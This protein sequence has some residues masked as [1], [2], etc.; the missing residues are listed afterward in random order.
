MG[1]GRSKSKKN[2]IEDEKPAREEIKPVAR[3]EQER[4]QSETAKSNQEV[5][6]IPKKVDV[7]TRREQMVVRFNETNGGRELFLAQI[8]GKIISLL[9]VDLDCWGTIISYLRV[10]DFINLSRVSKDF[11]I[12]SYQKLP[13]YRKFAISLSKEKEENNN[14]ERIGSDFS[15]DCLQSPQSLAWILIHG[16][17]HVQDL[18]I[19]VPKAGES[20]YDLDNELSLLFLL[21]CKELESLSVLI[22]SQRY[23]F[24]IPM[25]E[26][27]NLNTLK[28]LYLKNVVMDSSQWDS[29]LSGS[30]LESLKIVQT[31]NGNE[32][33]FDNP[34]IDQLS[35]VKGTLKRLTV[36][37]TCAIAKNQIPDFIFL[38]KLEDLSLKFFINF[39]EEEVDWKL[40]KGIKS[41]SIEYPTE[42]EP[43]KA[44]YDYE[45][46]S[47]DELSV[48]TGDQVVVFMKHPSG[49]WMCEMNGKVGLIPSNFLESL[50]TDI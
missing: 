29:F 13:F 36:E 15:S 16:G 7:K 23:K 43:Y 12:L 31:I 34:P 1:N 47:E 17:K 26:D 6:N 35:A 24:W 22:D 32:V 38:E 27:T 11:Y 45:S 4:N 25:S 10:S 18:T 44:M 2:D 21:L 20:E 37:K 41:Y 40:P 50:F 49:W 8:D 46:T 39:K 33:P 19:S 5:I 3:E 14:N 42:G 48:Q 9:G 30:K 28:N